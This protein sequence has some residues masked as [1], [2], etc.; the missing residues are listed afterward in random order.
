MLAN[1]CARPL[2]YRLAHGWAQAEQA[3]SAYFAP[4]ATFVPRFEEYLRDVRAMGFEAVDLWQPI[5]DYRWLSDQHLDAAAELLDDYGLTVVSF[6]GW[7]GATPDEFEQNCEI[8]AAL[9]SPLLCGDTSAAGEHRGFLV[10]TLLKFGL[11]WA[12]ENAAE[13]TPEAILARVGEDD[14]SGTI[15]VCADTGWFGTWNYDAAEA[16][17]RLSPRLF[18]VHLKDVLAHGTHQPCRYGAGVV[19]VRE[20]V[21]A[22]RESGYRGA[23]TVEIEG[24]AFD[25]TEDC[26]ASLNLL[27]G[28]LA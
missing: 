17:R 6:A 3:T 23:L 24:E 13:K 21:L 27:E 8:C 25:P 9:G 7:L 14:G 1:Y 4:L 22:L 28:W 10:D 26:I 19:P 11:K 18:H 15:G 5:L 16:L 2:G 20:C 12:Y